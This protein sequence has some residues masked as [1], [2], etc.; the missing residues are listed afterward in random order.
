MLARRTPVSGKE[1]TDVLK[2]LESLLCNGLCECGLFAL[3]LRLAALLNELV[4]DDGL[5][6]LRQHIDGLC[7]EIRIVGALH[8]LRF[9]ASLHHFKLIKNLI[10]FHISVKS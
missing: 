4:A 2:A 1:E 8:R 9:F 10:L 5:D 6:A 3:T 7:V